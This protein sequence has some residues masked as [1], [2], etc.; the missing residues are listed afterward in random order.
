[1]KLKYIVLIFFFTTALCACN[2]FLDI[3]PKG[4]ILPERVS[5]YEGLLNSRTLTQ[6]FQ[7][8]LLHF[9]DDNLNSF[10]ALNQSAVAN[11]Y[12]WR[13][14]ITINQK[15][16]PE[17]WGPL[18]NVIYSANVIINDVME[19]TDG[20]ME[21]KEQVMGEALVIRANCYLDLLT[22][23]AK[24]YNP[25][26][27]ATDPGLP[28]VTS[29]NVT[30]KAPMRSSVKAT[31]DLMISDV[32]KAAA[33]VP[34]SNLNRYRV[35][36]YVAYGLLSRIYLY[37]ADYVNAKKYAEMALV[38]PHS[39]LNYNS[40][41]SDMDFPDYEL[42]PEV[43][44]Q[45]TSIDYSAPSSMLYSVDLKTYFNNDDI[46][47]TFLTTTSNAGLG[48]GSLPG[49]YNFGISF[50]EMEL[51]KAEVLARQG[52]F[53]NS[54]IIVNALRKN[55]IK[56]GAYVDQNASTGEEALIKV[57]AER[58][59]ELAY[60]GLRWFDMKR[61][62]QDGRM[63]VVKRLNLDTQVIDATLAPHSAQYTFEIPVRVQMFNPGMELNHK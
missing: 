59:R 36:K 16:D 51:T 48:R 34:I 61:L 14:I 27:A 18:Y 62:D 21:K 17:V 63:P 2:K 12:Y 49:N 1:M 54:M 44:W 32:L 22:V 45:R 46:R 29:I 10:D 39:T 13:P 35:T 11:A 30:D 56:T 55:R 6:T 47:Y 28:L 15:A 19:A 31:L 60:S 25:A 4:L 5:D 53:T 42:S 3:K 43:L 37:M 38:A 26:T 57:L 23:F 52:N 40:F 8:S 33:S 50:P 58:R 41:A 9:T 20:T 24:A 7:V